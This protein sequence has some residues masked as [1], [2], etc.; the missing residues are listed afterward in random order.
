[1][2]ILYV[3]LL[4]LSVFELSFERADRRREFICFNFCSREYGCNNMCCTSSNAAILL[5]R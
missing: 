5:C 4:R 1:M 3:Q 2:S